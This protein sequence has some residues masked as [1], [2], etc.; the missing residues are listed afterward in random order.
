MPA[1]RVDGARRARR[2]ECRQHDVPDRRAQQVDQVHRG[3]AQHHGEDR[4][5][6][7]AAARPVLHRRGGRNGHRAVSLL[8]ARV[9]AHHPVRV[10]PRHPR[11]GDA[12]A[13]SRIRVLRAAVVLLADALALLALS[14]LLPGFTLDGFG[15]AFVA[16]VAVGVLNALVWPLLARLALPLSVVTLGLATLVLNGVLIVFAIDLVPGADIEDVWTGVGLAIGL[17][18]ITTLLASLLAIDEDESW[19]RNVV[20]RQA[21]RRGDHIETRRARRDLPRDRRPR[22]RGAAARDARRKRPDAR[23]LAARRHPS[24]RA[25]GDRLVVADRRLPGRPA[26]RQQRRHARVP[27]VGEGPRQ[28]DRHEPPARRGGARAAALGRPRAASRR[29]ARAAR[30]SSPATPPTRCSR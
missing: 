21:R 30:T 20:R 29:T 1:Q 25:L 8:P 6:N 23:A 18:L 27:L 3:H 12:L 22:P 4:A 7:H 2:D 11:A 13:V 28:G 14:E 17:T 16:A 5:S 10:T 15:A 9:K 19:Y 26:A 24:L